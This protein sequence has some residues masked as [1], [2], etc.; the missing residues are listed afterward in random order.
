WLLLR[1]AEVALAALDGDASEKDKP[2]Y[3]GK[4]AA[5]RFFAKNVL[6]ELKS[7][8]KIIEAADLSL[9]EVDESS[10]R[11]EEHTSELQSRE[12]LVCRLLLEKKKNKTSHR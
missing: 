5:A 6:P 3:Q 8:R 10:F 12:N 1:Q 9:M 2:F 7:R 11:S 4:L